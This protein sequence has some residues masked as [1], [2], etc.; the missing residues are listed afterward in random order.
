MISNF[1][2]PTNHALNMQE[3]D[4][5]VNTN[6]NAAPKQHSCNI[7]NDGSRQETDENKIR[8]EK[9][10][11]FI[12][13]HKSSRRRSDFKTPSFSNKT[14][15]GLGS[16]QSSIN[17]PNSMVTSSVDLT[18]AVSKSANSKNK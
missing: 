11:N 14:P 6:S 13:T 5:T 10:T 8:R 15:L 2:Q 7:S 12:Q 3:I 9:Q 16:K 1:E 4:L 18:P 17:L